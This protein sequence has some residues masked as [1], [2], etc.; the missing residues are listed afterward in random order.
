VL[1]TLSHGYDTIPEDSLREAGLIWAHI[2]GGSVHG[3]LDSLLWA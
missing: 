1:F 2:S 3:V